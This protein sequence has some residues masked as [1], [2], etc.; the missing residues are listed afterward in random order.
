MS[1]HGERRLLYMARR[2]FFVDDIRGDRAILRGESAEHLRRVLRALPGQ[3]FEV[4]RNQTAWL[5]EI[6]SF[7][8]QEVRFRLLE[9]LAVAAPPV[10]LTLLASLIKFDRFEWMLE[11]AAELGV[12][13]VLPVA[14][15]RSVKGLEQAAVRRAA[16][17]RKILLE[18]SQQAR[19]IAVPALGECLAWEQA[20]AQAGRCRF[21]LD[22]AGGGVPL[23][24]ALPEAATRSASDVVLL[25][26]GPE[27]G[28]TEQERLDA[29]GA[30]WTAVTLGPL[31]LRAETAAL[32]SL[33]ALW[34]AWQCGSECCP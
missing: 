29:G 24:A 23:L 7:G 22:E 8:R 4:C 3:R 1:D 16:R 19:R 15:E 31:V 33:S 17:W 21:F 25:L 14:A 2:R 5:A 20:L 30:G 10:R 12:E 6:E 34:L 26:T 27:G 32:A 9:E 13:R 11:K 18:S 28:W